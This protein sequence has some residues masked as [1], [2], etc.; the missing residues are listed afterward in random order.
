MLARGKPQDAILE[1]QSLLRQVPDSAHARYC[2]GLAHLQAENLAQARNEFREA[3]KNNPRFLPAH[4]MLAE[5]SL[6]LGDPDSA[7]QAAEKAMTIR[8]GIVGAK[9][10][11][12]S[13]LVLKGD[14]QD[15]QRVLGEYV[16]DVP[17]SEIGH[18][19]LGLAYL[20]GNQSERAENEFEAAL[21]LNPD[22]LDSL[23]ALA[24]IFL[25]QKKPE[26][27][28]ARVN[29]QIALRPDQARFHELAGQI[30]AGQK[31]MF[32]AEASLLKALSLDRK[33]SSAYMTLGQLYLAQNS[34]DKAVQVY[35]DQLKNEPLSTTARVAIGSIYELQNNIQQA[36]SQYE[37]ALKIDSTDPLAANNMAWILSEYDGNLDRALSLAQIAKQKLPD[38]LNVNDTLGRI[39]YRKNLFGLA[40]PLLKECVDKAP[41]NAAYH[42]HLGMA[43]LKSGQT[44]KAKALL[45]K[46]L[47][48]NPG[49][50]GA[51]EARKS[52]ATL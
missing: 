25:N 44:D 12:G 30:Y 49:F 47:Q 51:E 2:L 27:A 40:I 21:K 11:I 36:R 24:G 42:Y 32:R 20:T 50:P 5:T 33:L 16:K 34:P 46:A 15:A 1:M 39:Y 9:L 37:A 35:Q 13:S 14:P 31:D 28:I 41:Q 4:L 22:Y 17:N 19:Q 7:I 48:L 10:I 29:E 26:R 3:I 45:G 8:P 6:K 52:M 38:A 18:H 23:T 43:Y